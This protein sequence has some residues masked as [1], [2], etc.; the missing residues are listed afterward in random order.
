MEVK[1]LHLVSDS[2]GET[3]SMLVQACLVQFEDVTVEEHVWPMV[4]NKTEVKKVLKN[5]EKTPGLVIFTVIN[6]N[7]RHAL[8]D[9]FRDLNVPYLCALDSVLSA[10]GLYLGATI[11]PRPGRQHTLNAANYTRIE[12]INYALTHDDGQSASTLGLADVILVGVSRTSKTPTCVYLANRGVKAANVP[13]VPGVPLL[14]E[15]MTIKNL[16][17]VGLTKDPKYLVQVRQNRLAILQHDSHSDYADL[18]AV[19]RE[20][21][22]AQR[23]FIDHDWP[24]IDVTRKSIEETAT[25]IK[26]L[27]KVHQ[28]ANS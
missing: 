24:I 25:T 5:I 20:V 9:A 15:L 13:I 10:L 2:T 17:V 23:F 16:L 7:I 12:A 4:R 1:H 22:E 21:A 6:P 8:E 11:Q 28:E 14:N 27:L 18:E 3:V 19:R 26:Q